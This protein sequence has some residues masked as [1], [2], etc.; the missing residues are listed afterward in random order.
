M[1]KKRQRDTYQEENIYIEHKPETN[2]IKI[3]Q[4]PLDISNLPSDCAIHP[5]TGEIVRNLPPGAALHPV[6]GDIIRDSPCISNAD[7]LIMLKIKSKRRK[8]DQEKARLQLENS[9]SPPI[10][11]VQL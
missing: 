5:V 7:F 1:T 11:P 3:H 4:L 9:L 2:S 6:T 8:L 10:T